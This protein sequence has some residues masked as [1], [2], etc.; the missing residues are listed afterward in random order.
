M[1]EISRQANPNWLNLNNIR[2]Y[3]IAIIIIVSEKK[4]LS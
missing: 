2:L 4:T 1:N 3:F